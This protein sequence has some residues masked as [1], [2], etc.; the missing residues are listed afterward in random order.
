MV[1]SSGIVH[2][3]LIMCGFASALCGAFAQP[4]PPLSQAFALDALT[5][6]GSGAGG[7]A[8]QLSVLG[9]GTYVLQLTGGA[10][11]F[12]TPRCDACD[13]AGAGG[14]WLPQAGG[15]NVFAPDGTYLGCLGAGCGACFGG[16]PCTYVGAGRPWLDAQYSGTSGAWFS[17]CNPLLNTSCYGPP[18]CLDIAAGV[19]AIRLQLYDGPSPNAGAGWCF[20]NSGSLTGTLMRTTPAPPLPPSPPKP[21]LSPPLTLP[22]QVTSAASRTRNVLASIVVVALSVQLSF[23]ITDRRDFFCFSSPSLL[24]SRVCVSLHE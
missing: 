5:H 11:Y 14:F 16:A 10:V 7:P 19:G 9:P 22:P 24:A 18:L 2:T 23:L 13:P 20:D 17:N 1:T 15:V 21:P 12:A 8:L 4:S 3:A 6:C